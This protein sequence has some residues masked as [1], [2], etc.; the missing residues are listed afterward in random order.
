MAQMRREKLIAPE[1][2]AHGCRRVPT[3]V[4]VT[5]NGDRHLVRSL[6]NTIISSITWVRSGADYSELQGAWR[7]RDFV[8]VWT[9]LGHATHGSEERRESSHFETSK[10]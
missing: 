8:G 5:W 9:R 7:K 1:I 4:K 10:K 6:L 3:P 2:V